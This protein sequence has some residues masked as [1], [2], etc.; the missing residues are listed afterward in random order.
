MELVFRRG[1]LEAGAES[2]RNA[3]TPMNRGHESGIHLA[4]LPPDLPPAAGYFIEH[5]RLVTVSRRSARRYAVPMDQPRDCPFC[6][7]GDVAV[8]VVERHPLAYAVRCTECSATGPRMMSD[9]PQHAVTVW[10]Q[11]QGRLS[12]VR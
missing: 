8:L 1:M 9:D 3:K 4:D 7:H 12:V 2:N 11:R 10:N 5:L 6:A